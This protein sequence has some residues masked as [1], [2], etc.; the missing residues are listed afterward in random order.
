M[1]IEGDSAEYELL[2]MAVEQSSLV[3]GMCIEIGLRL[4]MGTYTIMQSVLLNCPNK[5]VVS[6]D[7]Y[8][9]IIYQGREHMEPCRLDY[10]HEMKN[11]CLSE[12]W[13]FVKENNLSFKYFDMT[14]EQFFKRFSD[15][16]PHYNEQEYLEAKYSMVHLDGPHSVKHVCMELDWFAPRMDAYATLVIDDCTPDF[17]Q[18][19]KVEEHMKGNFELLV[20]GEKKRIY[21][22]C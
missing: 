20:K 3:E 21:I 12:L 6:V 7:P 10:T 22:K 15:G 4:G 5:T 16:V 1:G 11:K 18:I 8:G 14:D 19:E 13:P 9:S 17:I 2:A